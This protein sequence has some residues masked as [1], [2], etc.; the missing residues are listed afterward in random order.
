MIYMRDRHTNKKKAENREETTTRNY[1]DEL[2]S[3]FAK[4]NTPASKEV[5]SRPENT[6][7]EN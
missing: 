7:K 1:I 3:K 6:R 2:K 4:K 5:D